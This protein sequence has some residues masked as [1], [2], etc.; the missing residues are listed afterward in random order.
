MPRARIADVAD[1]AGVSTATVSLVLRGRPGP[2][3]RTRSR[4]EAAAAELG[5]RPDRAASL[6]ARRSSDQVGVV[7]DIRSTFHAELVDVFDAV[8]ADAGLDLVLSTLTRRR[9][10]QAALDVLLDSRCAALIL[11]GTELPAAEVGALAQEVPTVVVGRAGIPEVTCVAADEQTGI[12]LAV[13]HLAELGHERITFIDGPRWTVATQR[14]RAYRAAMRARGLGG[15]VD[16]RRG[17]A[18]EAAG[19][20]AGEALL[21]AGDLPTAVIAFNDYCAVGARVA[22]ARGGV[23]VPEEIS[24]VGYDDSPIARLATV[25]LTSVSQ[26]PLALAEATIRSLRAQ[27]DRPEGTTSPPTEELRITPSLTVR[28]TTAPP[29]SHPLRP[30]EETT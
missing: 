1:R 7:L 16:V 2:G 30:P 10:E 29:R 4:V 8:A 9:D 3:E 11:L 15:H 23:A 13:G 28:S 19:M 17:G 5:Y 14:R 21:A 26:S 22:L 12:D 18:D 24:V 20:A 25:D 6:L 27:L